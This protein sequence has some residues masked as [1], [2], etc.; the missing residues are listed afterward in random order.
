MLL[1]K[2]QMLVENFSFLQEF[3]ICLN[4]VSR[5]TFRR[6]YQ[7]IQKI[8]NITMSVTKIGYFA[9]FGI[10]GNISGSF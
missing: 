1:I 4:Y 7:K 10:F 2:F 5:H 9:P 8:A 6:K 3:K